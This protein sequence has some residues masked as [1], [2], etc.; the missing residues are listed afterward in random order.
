MSDDEHAEVNETVSEPIAE[1]VASE[2]GEKVQVNNAQFQTF[3]DEASPKSNGANL[4][5]LMDLEMAITI[6]LG[7]TKLSVREV[8]DLGQG[9][10]IELDKLSGDPVDVFINDRRFARGEVVVVDEN[11]GVRITEILSPSEKLQSLQ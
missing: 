7:R 2:D 6:E 9:S 1:Q 10:I 8:L 5:M 4:D 11:F 3:A